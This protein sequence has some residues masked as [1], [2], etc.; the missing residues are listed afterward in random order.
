MHFDAA[1]GR[2]REVYDGGVV[3]HEVGGGDDELTLGFVNE[4]LQTLG[5][6][7]I[8]EV[9][10]GSERLGGDAVGSQGHR[11]H[12]KVDERLVGVEIPVFHEE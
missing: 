10:S 11:G 8:L 4:G 6:R 5:R 3:G 9:W 12:Q 7:Q 1:S 2:R